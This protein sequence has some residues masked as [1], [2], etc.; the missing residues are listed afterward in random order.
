MK[1]IRTTLGFWHGGRSAQWVPKQLWA[2]ALGL[3][4]SLGRKSGEN[5]RTGNCILDEKDGGSTRKRISPPL[6]K[7]LLC[8]DPHW[9]PALL[10]R[11]KKC[12]LQQ[13]N[14]R[15]A[16]VITVATQPGMLRVHLEG[17]PEGWGN[18]RRGSRRG[19]AYVIHGRGRLTPVKEQKIRKEQRGRGGLKGG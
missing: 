5:K 14:S 1:S 10:S 19:V 8:A 16:C 3:K 12:K 2:C 13:P 7:I 18:A 6:P 15:T 17:Q 4:F 9:E 11:R